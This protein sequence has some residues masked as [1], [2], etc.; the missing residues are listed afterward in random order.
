MTQPIT[1]N[2]R[3]RHKKNA[4]QVIVT[5]VTFREVSYMALDKSCSGTLPHWQFLQVFQPVTERKKKG[6]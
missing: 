5:S 4:A 6:Q 2:S 1:V 3:R